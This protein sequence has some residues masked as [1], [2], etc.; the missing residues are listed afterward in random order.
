MA[1]MARVRLTERGSKLHALH[2]QILSMQCPP[3]TAKPTGAAS[4]ERRDKVRADALSSAIM[5]CPMKA[6]Q[7]G[8]YRLYL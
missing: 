6:T 7:F 1:R 8:E 3:P 5:T 4:A 2:P